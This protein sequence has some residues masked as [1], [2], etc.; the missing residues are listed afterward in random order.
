MAVGIETTVE[1]VVIACDHGQK[2]IVKLLLEQPEGTIDFN[3]KTPYDL[4]ARRKILKAKKDGNKDLI[5]QALLNGRN[6][7]QQTTALQFACE[8]YN[9]L[10][11]SSWSESL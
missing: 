2:D 5:K 10:K 4:Y 8:S 6:L 7:L 11:S 9:K 3:A 1:V